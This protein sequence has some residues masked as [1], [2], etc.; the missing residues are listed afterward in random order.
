M[1]T[2]QFLTYIEEN[3]YAHLEQ[4]HRNPDVLERVPNRIMLSNSTMRMC[5]PMQAVKQPKHERTSSTEEQK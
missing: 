4:C 3:N 5:A 2:L 1:L